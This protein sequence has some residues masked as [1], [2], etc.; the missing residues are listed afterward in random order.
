MWFGSGPRGQLVFGLPGNPVSTQV[1]TL[2]YVIPAL[3]AAM[4]Q[5]PAAPE[6]IATAGETPGR[7]MTYFMPVALQNMPGG[8]TRASAR[9]PQGSGDFLALAG[10]A[11]FIELTPQPEAYPAGFIADFY[12]W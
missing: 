11:G 12:R 1:C 3:R 2:R 5:T 10:T 8:A 9:A 7:K 6:R 4:G